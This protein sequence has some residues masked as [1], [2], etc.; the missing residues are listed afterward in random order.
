MEKIYQKLKLT[1]V[2]LVTYSSDKVHDAKCLMPGLSE[3]YK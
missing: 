1:Q 2:E 3:I